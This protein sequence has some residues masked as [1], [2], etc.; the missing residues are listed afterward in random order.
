MHSSLGCSYLQDD[1][2]ATVTVVQIS[3]EEEESH[4]GGSMPDQ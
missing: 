1:L 4:W 2:L 3:E